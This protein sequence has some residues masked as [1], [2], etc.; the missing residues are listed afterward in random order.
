VTYYD[1]DKEQVSEVFINDEAERIRRR[2]TETI[3]ELE[4][5]GKPY[6]QFTKT[7]DEMIATIENIHGKEEAGKI[8]SQLTLI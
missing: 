4:E 3:N 6:H 2:I 8:K 7:F 1:L 5:G